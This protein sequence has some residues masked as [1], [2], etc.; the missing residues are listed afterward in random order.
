VI[1]ICKEEEAKAKVCFQ[2]IH[3]LG[4]SPL[5]NCMGGRCMAW[6]KCEPLYDDIK[7][8][9]VYPEV[10]YCGLAGKPE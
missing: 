8:E 2:A 7:K 9:L 5:I 4:M 3:M 1:N 10:G 6:C